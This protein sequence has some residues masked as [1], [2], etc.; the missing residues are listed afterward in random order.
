MCVC[1][2]VLLSRFRWT[3]CQCYTCLA[4]CPS[5]L[6]FYTYTTLPVGRKFDLLFKWNAVA[7]LTLV[8]V[9]VFSLSSLLSFPLLCVFSSFFQITYVNNPSSLHL[10]NVLDLFHAAYTYYVVIVS[11]CVWVCLV[12]NTFVALWFLFLFVFVF[13]FFFVCLTVKRSERA[14]VRFAHYLSLAIFALILCAGKMKIKTRI[15]DSV[16]FCFVIIIIIICIERRTVANYIYSVHTLMPCCEI[17]PAASADF[18]FLA[19]TL[20]YPTIRR[21]RR[22]HAAAAA[23]AAALFAS[24]FCDRFTVRIFKYFRLTSSLALLCHC[25]HMH[26]AHSV[27][28]RA[29]ARSRSHRLRSLCVSVWNNISHAHSQHARPRSRAPTLLVAVRSLA[30]SVA[31]TPTRSVCYKSESHWTI[32]FE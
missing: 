6:F 8:A 29:R 10:V 4:A 30:R 27:L 9:L 19:L 26:A 32:S 31:R 16:L 15:D 23:A 12:S 3:A 22:R 20:I 7:L 25:T 11:V 13:V 28:S 18:L 21:R 24:S 2:C 14:R 17:W 5:V 1:V